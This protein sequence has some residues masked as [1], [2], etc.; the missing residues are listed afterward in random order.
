MSEPLTSP[1][2][3]RRFR[4]LALSFSVLCCALL[5]STGAQALYKV[6]GPDGKVTYTDQAPTVENKA[7]QVTPVGTS[8]RTAPA[9]PTANLPYELR[10]VVSS[11]P[12]TLYT[13]KLDC[14]PCDLGRALLKRRGVP[15]AERM[16]ISK[17]DFEALKSLTGAQSAPVMVVGSQVNLGFSEEVWNQYLDLAGYPETSKLPASFDFG[18]A[19]PLTKEQQATVPEAA[20]GSQ[21]PAQIPTAPPGTRAG[22]TAN[23]PA[24]GQ[25]SLSTPQDPNAIRF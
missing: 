9:R 17:A 22:Q 12:V 23:K 13:V 10:Q 14:A 21:R 8:G 18:A 3:H 15:F 1:L 6:V 20:A 25:S 11:Y 2:A 4:P 7:G 24:P 16:V 19:T 5:A